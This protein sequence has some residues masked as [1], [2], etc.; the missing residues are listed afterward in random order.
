MK[1]IVA[2]MQTVIQSQA[3]RER[4][5]SESESA[6][7]AEALRVQRSVPWLGPWA[8]RWEQ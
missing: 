5:Q 7:R 2:R 8:Q 3:L 1:T 4:I 6:R